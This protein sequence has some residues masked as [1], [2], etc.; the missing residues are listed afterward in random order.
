MKANELLNLLFESS[1][2]R[3]DLLKKVEKS[4]KN[5]FDNIELTDELC[6]RVDEETYSF[7][8]DYKLGN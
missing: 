1:T 5:V 6:A 4:V 7:I 8:H 3:N 2:L